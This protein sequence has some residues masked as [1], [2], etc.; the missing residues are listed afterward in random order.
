MRVHQNQQLQIDTQSEMLY[1]ITQSAVNFF[2]VIL[3]VVMLLKLTFECCI[4]KRLYCCNCAESMSH[5]L[6]IYNLF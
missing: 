5:D 2:T 6:Y 4:I 1:N 3:M